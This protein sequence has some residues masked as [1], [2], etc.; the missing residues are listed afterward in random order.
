MARVPK[1]TK[2]PGI[3]VF[4]AILLIT[5]VCIRLGVRSYNVLQTPIDDM[6]NKFYTLVLVL[7]IAIPA[8]LMILFYEVRKLI[9]YLNYVEMY[10]NPY[11]ED[12]KDGSIA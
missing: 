10:G 1:L 12:S 3:S 2:K 4:A 11:Y 7:C 5:A 9:G 6:T 8:V